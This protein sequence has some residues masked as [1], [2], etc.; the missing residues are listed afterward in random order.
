MTRPARVGDLLATVLEEAG[1]R[2]QVERAGV[3]DEWAERVGEQ[4]A[5]VTRAVVVDGNRIVVEVRSSSW[6]MELDVMKRE[7]LA[8]LNEGRSETPIERIVFVLAE[9]G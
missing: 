3:V 5:D 2:A 8:R 1:V 6:L 7:I 4:I 9:T